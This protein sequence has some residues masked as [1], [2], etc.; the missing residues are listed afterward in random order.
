MSV[1]HNNMNVEELKEYLLILIDMEQSKYIQQ[2]VIEALEAD[3]KRLK[4]DIERLE[5]AGSQY[6]KPT[7]PKADNI[8]TFNMVGGVVAIIIACL[9]YRWGSSMMWSADLL[10]PFV[11]LAVVIFGAIILLFGIVGI[12]AWIME[13][14]S[15]IKARKANREKYIVEML[16]YEGNVKREQAQNQKE[17]RK[18]QIKIQVTE[19]EL[20]L[21]SQLNDATDKALAALYAENIIYKDYRTLPCLCSI[22][23][24]LDSRRTESLYGENGAYGI[25]EREIYQR[26]IITK[27]DTIIS[28][29]HQ[30]KSNQG[31]LYRV[32]TEAN[33]RI[34][35]L[36]SETHNLTTKMSAIQ[37][38]G[39]GT[40]VELEE[41][42]KQSS[43][44]AYYAERTAKGIEYANR[45]DYLCGRNDAAPFNVPPS[46]T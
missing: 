43:I 6:T 30:I 1:E 14:Y 39:A 15:S 5:T 27:L 26:L 29:L 3:H 9:L 46:N 11:G 13:K 12:V 45:M 44:S 33:D 17:L 36:V 20:S 16:T 21:L 22:Y 8:E 38:Q 2:N 40:L 24:Y 10:L 19:S 34:A 37:N 25:L 23:K 32:M 28:L 18:N 41:L 31:E 7:A 42:R 4:A 35:S